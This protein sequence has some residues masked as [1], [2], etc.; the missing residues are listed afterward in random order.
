MEA[1]DIVRLKKKHPC[2]SDKWQVVRTGVDI[3]IQCLGCHRSVLVPRTALEN[4]IKEI[5]RNSEL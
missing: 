1:G 2:G 5:V 4:K 3:R